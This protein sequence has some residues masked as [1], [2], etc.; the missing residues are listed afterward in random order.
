MTRTQTLPAW[1][2]EACA[3]PLVSS[4]TLEDAL[5]DVEVARSLERPGVRA[6]VAGG[7]GCTA[8]A[9]G[10]LPEVE[11]VHLV[12]ENP[13]QLALSRLKVHLLRVDPAERLGL[14]GHVPLSAQTRAERLE[15]A[16][17]E[18]DL[19]PEA[20]GPPELVARE[21]PDYAGRLEHVLAALR[22]ELDL[23][24]SCLQELLDLRDL[25]E[26]QRRVGPETT[27]GRALDRAFAAVL[28]PGV[29]EALLGRIDE[30]DA[31]LARQLAERTRR[32]LGSRPAAG[33]PY[34]WQMLAGRFPH[35][36]RTPWL[37]SGPRAR[38]VEVAADAAAPVEVLA[39]GADAA[40]DTIHLSAGLDGL[41]AD[42]LGDLLAQ[43]WR[44]LRPG[45]AVVVRLFSN[46]VDVP[47]CGP[48]LD[49]DAEYAERLQDEGRCCF[50]AS[51]HVG[52][53]P[54]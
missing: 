16:L 46:G 17:A 15:A 3:L 5:Q 50:A 12:D 27:L 19:E 33:N 1:A 18:L 35:G 7:G 22:S 4:Q 28:A 37:E 6:L 23:H 10:A 14:L 32:A 20:L 54:A 42:E 24:H 43:A 25:P 26:Q 47:A 29:V 36:A 2:R 49:W 53:K 8:A 48:D 45:G 52:R 11:G 41:D 9:L 38:P 34:L 31:P 44:R 39:D 30:A 13:A 21:G 40:Y 51:L